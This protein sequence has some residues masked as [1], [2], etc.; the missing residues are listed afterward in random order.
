[1]KLKEA[2]N[3]KMSLNQIQTKYWEQGINQKYK[4]REAVI[5][6]FNDYSSIASGAKHKATHGKIIP[7]I[8]ASPT[9][10]SDHSRP[11]N[12]ARVAK[13]SERSCLKIL[14]P[15]Q[16]LQRLLIAL[17]QIALAQNR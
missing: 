16:M 17:A 4:K 2:K 3:C 6:L 5:K 15:K 12:V 10:P 9:K 7:G 8:L 1:M 14:A 13:V 11:L